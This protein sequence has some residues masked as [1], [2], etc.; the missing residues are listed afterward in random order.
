LLEGKVYTLALAA[1]SGNA[2]HSWKMNR[3]GKEKEQHAGLFIKFIYI[4]LKENKSK[5]RTKTCFT[6]YQNGIFHPEFVLVLG[7]N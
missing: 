7:L 6:P 1:R 3:I 4:S 5:V 2:G